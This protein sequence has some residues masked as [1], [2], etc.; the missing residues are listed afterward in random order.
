VVIW[1][2]TELVLSF[3]LIHN[4]RAI[5]SGSLEKTRIKE[6]LA[7]VISNWFAKVILGH[8]GIFFSCQ[9]ENFQN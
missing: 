7:L 3:R 5:G 4:Q 1:I 9:N 2:C 6:L 8:S